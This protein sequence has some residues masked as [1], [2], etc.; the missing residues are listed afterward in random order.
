MAEDPPT[1][2][3]TAERFD[4]DYYERVYTVS[5]VKRF[6]IHWWANRYYARLAERLLR[7]TGGTTLLDV[8]CGQGF[9][10]GQLGPRITCWGIEISEYALSRC[11]IFAPAARIF[12]GNIE[13][14]LPPGV[15]TG[16]FDVVVAR[17]VLEHLRDPAAAI[18]RCASLLRPG[19][20]FLFSVPNT[21]SPGTRLKGDQWFAALDETHISLLPPD[22]WR[23]LITASGLHLEKV[24]SDGLWDVPYI[25]GVPRLVQYGLFSVPTILAVFFVS[26][27]LPVSWGENLIGYARK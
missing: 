9:M 24:F 1:G 22:E 18:A 21:E 23:R 11:A 6:D 13:D 16:E 10:L 2:D 27:A 12:L 17:Y 26:T 25:R 5:G 4:A 3:P 15:P 14:G 20:Y 19:G 7:R 8:G